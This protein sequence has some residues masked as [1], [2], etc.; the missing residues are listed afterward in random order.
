MLAG[1][2]RR[3]HHGCA[4][5]RTHDKTEFAGVSEESLKKTAL[6]SKGKDRCQSPGPAFRTASST[7]TKKLGFSIGAG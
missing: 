1:D 6:C 7:P 5:R 4:L 2:Q 3:V